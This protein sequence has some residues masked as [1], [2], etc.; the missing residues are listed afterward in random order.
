METKETVTVYAGFDADGKKSISLHEGMHETFYV[1]EI[2]KEELYRILNASDVQP[3]LD[4]Y[5]D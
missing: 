1:F 5:V 3:I 4:Y 2:T